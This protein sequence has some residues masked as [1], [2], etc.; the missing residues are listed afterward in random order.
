MSS[1]TR[2]IL[3][4]LLIAT[5][6]ATLFFV[7]HS[8]D[9]ATENY[10]DILFYEINPDNQDLRF[11]SK[12]ENGQAFENHAHLKRWLADNNKELVFATNGGMYKKDLS[13]QGLYIENGEV[14]SEMNKRK[15]G[16]GNFYLQPNGIFYISEQSKPF[17]KTTNSYKELH[18]VKYATQSGPMLVI[19]GNIHPKFNEDSENLHIRNGV[20]ILPNGNLLFAMSKEKVN[21][22]RFARFFQDNQC[23]NAL[24]LDGFVSRTYLPSKNWIQEDGQYGIIIAEIK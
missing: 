19:D 9:S 5:I 18:Q 12:D 15:E 4:T 14:I 8:S 10:P 23:K 6:G 24:Y 2:I 1:A 13:P 22:Y 21:F 17:I 16:Y 11:Y 7:L 20:G 3:I